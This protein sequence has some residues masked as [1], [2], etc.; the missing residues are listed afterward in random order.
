[1]ES[2]NKNVG[3]KPAESKELRCTACGHVCEVVDDGEYVAPVSKCCTAFIQ[4][5]NVFTCGTT[6]V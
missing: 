5:F 3:T 1:M 4:E 2:E 6:K